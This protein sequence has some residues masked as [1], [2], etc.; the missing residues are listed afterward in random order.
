MPGYG[1]AALRRD[2]EGFILD[3]VAK[4]VRAEKGQLKAAG[5]AQEPFALYRSVQSCHEIPVR[6]IIQNQL[7]QTAHR[8]KPRRNIIQRE[9]R[10]KAVPWKDAAENHD[11]R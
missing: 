7:L 6:H 11:L 4:G 10:L 1:M 9:T 3:G 8:V 5:G 2:R